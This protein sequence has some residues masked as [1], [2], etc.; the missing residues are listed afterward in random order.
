MINIPAVCSHS[1]KH[2]SIG[3]LLGGK[4]TKT[5]WE[6]L[7]LY[8][9]CGDDEKMAASCPSGLGNKADGSGIHRESRH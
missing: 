3:C 8:A 9:G 6:W 4:K 5:E 7:W 2:T 1:L